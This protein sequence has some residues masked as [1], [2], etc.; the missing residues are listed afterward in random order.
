MANRANLL[1]KMT[2]ERQTKL[3]ILSKNI[4][5]FTGMKRETRAIF[6][7]ERN[8]ILTSF[9]YRKY[10]RCFAIIQKVA[11]LLLW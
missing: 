6:G 9:I 11:C 8:V 2:C 3:K 4:S 5:A 10:Y 1:T 7:E